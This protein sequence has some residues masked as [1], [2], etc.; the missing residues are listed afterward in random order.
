MDADGRKH[1]AP[2]GE[3]DFL[4]NL[5]DTSLDAPGD[6]GSSW[7]TDPGRTPGANRVNVD[8]NLRSRLAQPRFQH[9]SRASRISP[10][11]SPGSFRAHIILE[12]PTLV[13]AMNAIPCS[14][15]LILVSCRLA[16]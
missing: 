5:P 10:Q 13:N 12:T 1:T 11:E 15:I 9:S 6:Y 3:F 8:A 14:E 2:N 7:T 4:R 16:V